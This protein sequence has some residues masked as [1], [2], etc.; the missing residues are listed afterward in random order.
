MMSGPVGFVGL[1][2]M[3]RPMAQRLLEAGHEVVVWNR[4]RAIAEALEEG[5]ASVAQSPLE[6]GERCD[7][8]L[9]CLL[10]SHAVADVYGRHDG[11]LAAGRKGQVF[12]EHGTFSPHVAVDIA[13]R[14]ATRGASFLDAPVSGGPEGAAA[15]RLVVMV[16]GEVSAL[17]SAG[18]VIEAYASNVVHVGPTA[19]AL[20]LKLINQL[21]VTYHVIGAAEALMM[22]ESLDISRDVAANVL[23]GGFAA[24]ALLGRTLDLADRDPIEG[25]APIGGM[26][27][28]QRL[29][30]AE[31]DAV[32][33][34]LRLFD[35]AREIFAEA[36]EAGLERTD[37]SFL[38]ELY[39][40][41]T[42]DE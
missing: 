2:Q 27:E 3:G 17:E 12:V 8:V 1:G 19:S 33:V 31:A 11:L 38:A 15:G 42:R 36:V 9:S 20:R 14:A 30:A 26:I 34:Q 13:A 37:F 16:G 25:G 18:P 28:L 21:L 41:E 4:T 6:V 24:S 32:G 22:L 5:A 40:Q 39:R 23:Q 7:L 29:I 35:R 10:D